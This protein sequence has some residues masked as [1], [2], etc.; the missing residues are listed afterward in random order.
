MLRRN[1]GIGIRRDRD[2]NARKNVLARGYACVRVGDRIVT[3]AAE[4]SAGQSICVDMHAV[5]V[6]ATVDGVDERK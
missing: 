2:E 4:L 5:R 6:R 3:D 1:A